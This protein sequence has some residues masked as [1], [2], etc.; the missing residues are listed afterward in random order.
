MMGNA[1]DG[2]LEHSQR[3]SLCQDADLEVDVGRGWHV[4]VDS[5]H[6]Q[7]HEELLRL[8]SIQAADG[9]VLQLPRDVLVVK[10]QLQ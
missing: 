10:R 4:H 9:A 6:R 3:Q 1:F 5:C 2:S 8:D 7:P